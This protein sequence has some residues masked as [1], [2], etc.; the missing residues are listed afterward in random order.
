MALRRTRS[1]A[2]KEEDEK[3]PNT[4]NLKLEQKPGRRPLDDNEGKVISPQ[5]ER[6][7]TSGALSRRILFGV[8][9]PYLRIGLATLRIKSRTLERNVEVVYIQVD[10][11]P[12]IQGV[13]VE[14]LVVA[15]KSIQAWSSRNGEDGGANLWAVLSQEGIQYR[16]LVVALD[17]LMRKDLSEVQEGSTQ[18]AEISVLASTLF[19][20]M[21]QIAGNYNFANPIAL[22]SSFRV[23]RD[24][25]KKKKTAKKKE[26][27][28]WESEPL[29][30]MLKEYLNALTKTFVKLQ[31]SEDMLSYSIENLI[32]ATRASCD[33]SI[34]SKLFL[35]L[36]NT[37]S[38]VQSS[39]SLT[40]KMILKG[41]KSNIL[42]EQSQ[43]IGQTQYR[44][45]VKAVRKMSL[46][47]VKKIGNKYQDLVPRILVLIHHLC[48][49]CPEKT[50]PRGLT[51]SAVLE[52]L[53]EFPSLVEQKDFCKF[54]RLLSRNGRVGRR[55]LPVELAGKAIQEPTLFSSKNNAKKPAPTSIPATP[56]AD[57]MG[58]DG[59]EK[60]AKAKT[61]MEE[62]EEKEEEKQEQKAPPVD[63]IAQRQRPGRSLL[64]VIISRCSDR[65]AIVTAA[66]LKV[67]GET[68]EAIPSSPFLSAEFFSLVRI[69][70]LS[71]GGLNFKNC[72][73]ALET[74]VLSRWAPDT[75]Q[76]Q[77]QQGGGFLHLLEKRC[78]DPRPGVRKASVKVLEALLTCDP[79]IS[80]GGAGTGLLSEANL[81]AIFDACMDASISVRKQ[82]MDSIS[83]LIECYPQDTILQKIWLGI[84]QPSITDMISGGAEGSPS[85]ESKLG[86]VFSAVRAHAFTTLGKFCLRN[87][88]LTRKMRVSFQKPEILLTATCAG[89]I[90]V[91]PVMIRELKSG[92]SPVVRNNVL[93]VLCDMCRAFTDA[94][95]GQI[96]AITACL[97]DDNEVVRRHSLM[98]MIQLLQEDYIKWK[99]PMFF[100]ALRTVV[101]SDQ[102]VKLTAKGALTKLIV[103]KWPRQFHKHFVEAIFYLN[104]YRSHK[105]YN[106]FS[107]SSSSADSSEETKFAL[108]G[109]EMEPLRRHLYQYMLKFMQD[110]HKFNTVCKLCQDII[111]AYFK[112]L[113]SCTLN[114]PASVGV[115]EKQIR[116]DGPD[117]KKAHAVLTDC[118]SVLASKGIK[119]RGSREQYLDHDFVDD[120]VLRLEAAGARYCPR[121][122]EK[123]NDAWWRMIEQH[124][125]SWKG[126]KKKKRSSYSNTSEEDD[127]EFLLASAT[128]ALGNIALKQ[129]I[130]DGKK[131]ICSRMLSGLSKGVCGLRVVKSYVKAL[132]AMMTSEG[133][134]SSS[135]SSLWDAQLLKQCTER[136]RNYLFQKNKSANTKISED[137]VHLVVVVWERLKWLIPGFG[138]FF[139]KGEGVVMSHP[140][141]DNVKINAEEN[142][143]PLLI[144]L[145]HLLERRRS[146]VIKPLMAYLKELLS[147]YKDEIDEILVSDPQLAAELKYDL[148][149]F[150]ERER[151][152]KER[153]LQDLKSIGCLSTPI[154][155]MPSVTPRKNQQPSSR[156][157][158]MPASSSSSRRKSCR[159]STPRLKNPSSAR[160]LNKAAT[161]SL[162]MLQQRPQ[163][164]LSD[165]KVNQPSSKGGSS[166]SSSTT[167]N[168]KTTAKGGK[169]NKT[170]GSRDKGGAGVFKTPAP[171][172]IGK[173]RVHPSPAY[174]DTKIVRSPP[175]KNIRVNG[176]EPEHRSQ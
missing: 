136:I 129:P 85:D 3:C 60:E 172:K 156:Q 157:T 135:S 5:L 164:P 50:E 35:A 28:V 56:R 42:M 160:K 53:V 20:E 68:I 75:R 69:N 63:D 4:E 101:D 13:E 115:V 113:A 154:V 25:A 117:G 14:D 65:A 140:D 19:L 70:E 76:Q 159:F 171:V 83:N 38:E 127:S 72:S 152:T 1:R 52:L 98:I 78:A 11:N 163:P 130:E 2:G 93:V 161:S 105:T 90:V 96:D 108:C 47:F 55:V 126:E 124:E 95:D 17:S 36:E 39:R 118:L 64:N 103:A 43:R 151:K 119:L 37:M 9:N 33:N 49:Y 22:R 153:C 132:S 41:I 82:G 107:A 80:N 147:D 134:S 169:G 58:R 26:I 122:S 8:R 23:L 120:R 84:L 30:S 137:E 92:E 97:R 87:K 112:L 67:L 21:A 145:K 131:R 166:S 128:E 106:K 7:R 24:Y 133:S 155:G 165:L 104:D 79:Q 66:A 109:K 34:S 57:A 175:T 94:V 141:K 45:Q 15:V 144:E 170:A 111:G 74:D 27:T 174:N 46:S 32:E 99:G 102:G 16:P 40:W 86:G 59:E 31:V 12:L 168:T 143:V 146:P 71:R 73:I 173:R 77:Q 54:V 18:D 123:R 91:V 116:L 162:S 138:V 150:E 158:P 88:S 89:D 121:S 6:G 48:F 110:E 167:K 139:P 114:A 142:I 149:Q 81:Q 51:V 44:Q 62:E 148:E 176:D 125:A 61:D 10:S 100:R 29:G